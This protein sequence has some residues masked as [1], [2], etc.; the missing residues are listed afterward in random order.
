VFGLTFGF[1]FYP[2]KTKS[3]TK[4]LNPGSSFFFLKAD[5]LAVQKLKHSWTYF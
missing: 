5:F 4:G 2:L 3:P 1:D